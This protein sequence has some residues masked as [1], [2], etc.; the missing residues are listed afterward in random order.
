[1]DEVR[2]NVVEVYNA[3][4]YEDGFY[5]VHQRTLRVGVTLCQIYD[6]RSF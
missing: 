1:M 6:L 4:V 3:L 5:T 2:G